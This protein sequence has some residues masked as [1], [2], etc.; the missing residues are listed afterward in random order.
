[1]SNVET[2]LK[3]V[4]SAPSYLELRQGGGLGQKIVTK[5]FETTKKQTTVIVVV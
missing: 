3:W 2:C 5:P 1:M 4:H